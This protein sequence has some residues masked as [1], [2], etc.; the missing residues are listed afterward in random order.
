VVF[1]WALNVAWPQSLLGNLFPEL[2]AV[3]GLI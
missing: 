2:R 3:T 1:H